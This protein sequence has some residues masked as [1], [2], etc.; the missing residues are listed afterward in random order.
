MGKFKTF[1]MTLALVLAITSFAVAQNGRLELVLDP[2]DECLTGAGDEFTVE[3]Q[4]S[5]LTQ[6]INGVQIRLEFDTAELTYNGGSVGGG[7]TCIGTPTNPWDCGTEVEDTYDN[8]V[9]GNILW[10]GVLIGSSQCTAIGG[11]VARLTFETVGATTGASIEFRP[12]DG[13]ERTV[14]TKCDSSAVTYLTLI[15]LVGAIVIDDTDPVVSALTITDDGVHDDAIVMAGDTLTVDFTASDAGGGPAPTVTYVITGSDASTLGSGLA[16]F[17][18]GTAY[19]VTY[20]PNAADPNGQAVVT[21]TAE[22]CSGN[23]A[24]STGPFNIDTNAPTCSVD[25]AA[26]PHSIPPFDASDDQYATVGDV[27]ITISAEDTLEDGYASGLDTAAPLYPFEA[28]ACTVDTVLTS[29]MATV[30]TTSSGTTYYYSYTVVDPGAH[31]H[32]GVAAVNFE[33]ADIAGNPCVNAGAFTIDT[34]DPVL[35]ITA[36]TQNGNNVMLSNPSPIDAIVGSVNAKLTASDALAGMNT[37]PVMTAQ[38]SAAA[39]LTVA[40]VNESPAGTFN[41]TIDVTTG[42]AN[43]T[44]DVDATVADNATNTGDAVQEHFIIN[45][46]QILVDVQLE[47]LGNAISRTV[48]FWVS[49]C[50]GAGSTLAINKSIA[51]DAFGF[52]FTALTGGDGIRA[53]LTNFD[54]SAKEAHVLRRLIS[55]QTLVGGQ[56]NIAFTQAGGP[57][58]HLLAGDFNTDNFVDVLDFSIL[59][60]HFNTTNTQADVDGNGLTDSPD[61][62]AIVANFFVHGD[63]KAT[64]NSTEPLTGTRPQRS[65]SVGSLAPAVSWASDLNGDGVVN[66]TDIKAFAKVHGL[67]IPRDAHRSL[68]RMS[69]QALSVR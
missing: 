64:C 38:D 16:N 2:A 67:T 68:Q 24:V 50:G 12:D 22:D 53:N 69:N 46:N 18:G 5:L 1:G 49:D 61:F 66:T 28:G 52:G 13:L 35:D 26:Q 11:T 43:G 51:F 29:G 9:A 7:G 33:V 57:N 8:G 3:L 20:V 36:L 4:V 34:T 15:D 47:G 42:S 37:T 23:T 55:G 62:S 25:D 59:A 14:L 6:A 48:T 10:A 39:P 19:R 56:A 17:L 65:V 60:T 45:K 63:Y 31:E 27:D 40:Y 54:I 44:A 41:Y 21:V 58:T 30:F 32:D